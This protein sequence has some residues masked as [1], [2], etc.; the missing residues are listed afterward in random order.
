MIRVLGLALYGSLAA[1]HRV[2]IRNYKEGLAGAGI[3]LTV[4]SILDNL[5]L[6][7]RFKEKSTRILPIIHAYCAR[8]I[9]LNQ[10]RFDI[11]VVQCELFPFAP[12]W[13]ER[14]LIR[15]PYIYDFDDAWYLR[16][17]TGKFSSLAPLL[18]NKVDSMIKNAAAVTAGNMHLSNY[19]MRLNKEVTLLPSV[20]DTRVYTPRMRREKETVLTVG[21]IG[22]PSTAVYLRELVAPLQTLARDGGIKFVVVGAIAPTIDGVEVVQLPWSEETEVELI[23]TFDIGVMPLFNDDWAHGKCAFKLVQYMAC[24]VPVVA[25]NVGANIDVV[26]HD[27]GFLVNAAPEWVHAIRCL[28]NQSSLREAMGARSRERIKQYYSLESNLPLLTS[29][30]YKVVETD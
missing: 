25:S 11:A 10:S 6:E 27:C 14:N 28:W 5:Y 24:G 8:F 21:W 23:N 16:Y 19:A 4:H 2:R 3:E 15:I 22:S 7:N 26:A 18:G 29:I 13:F 17:N 12:S 20:V 9:L 1:S 30:I